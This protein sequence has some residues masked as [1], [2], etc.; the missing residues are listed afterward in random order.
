MS[1]EQT[2][3]WEGSQT[4]R[5]TASGLHEDT[6]RIVPNYRKQEALLKLRL[7]TLC[8]TYADMKFQ[9]AVGGEQDN[10]PASRAYGTAYFD[11]P[12]E[13]TDTADIERLTYIRGARRV[14]I[15]PEE[16]VIEF[17]SWQ[18]LV[19]P[20]LRLDLKEPAE[21]TLAVP[22]VTLHKELPLG[23]DVMQFAD[24]R[25]VGGVRLEKRHPDY[26]RPPT[27]ERYD[28]WI[29]VIDGHT[30]Q[31]LPECRVDIWQW[32][33]KLPT[34]YGRGGFKLDM[35]AWTDGSGGVEVQGRPSGQL[36]AYSVRL[37]GRRVV[38]RCLRPLA[39]Q[40]VRLHMRAWRL[41][42][43]S[44]RYTWSTSDTLERIAALTGHGENEILSLNRLKTASVL[45]PGLV[46]NLP[47][48]AGAYQLESWDDPGW[49]G[50]A[51]GYKDADGLLK[52]SGLRGW[53]D[54]HPDAGLKLPD[55]HFFY[56]RE[57][58]TLDS[59]DRMFGLRE[60]SAVTVGR[61]YR[62]DRRLLF[63]G[64]TVAV[65]SSVFARA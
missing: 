12:V 59:I 19:I 32:D 43:A 18:D 60:G 25:H 40:K 49:V 46:I 33:P 20:R 5:L 57:G 21:A 55:W 9:N 39:G 24:G 64:E 52:K 6:L 27:K 31:P 23:I 35:S 62:P 54:Y 29:R 14:T 1:A 8:I 13:I 51:F 15:G 7:P 3:T 56:A 48:W 38:P 16:T 63:A 30:L 58:D 4:F 47:C 41:K 26:K 2:V 42:T 11:P 34:P 45:V 65:P 37:P 36:E 17:G 61:V 10:Y 50:A 53:S 44:I 28:L 22:E